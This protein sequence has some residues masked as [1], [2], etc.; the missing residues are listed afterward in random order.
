MELIDASPTHIQRT[1]D[2]GWMFQYGK[3]LVGQRCGVAY[4]NSQNPQY[5]LYKVIERKG[6]PFFER[7]SERT[8]TVKELEHFEALI[9]VMQ[10]ASNNRE[11]TRFF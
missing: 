1:S 7:E 11:D 2:D 9:E 8:L 6:K 4:V 5:V 10:M 3:G